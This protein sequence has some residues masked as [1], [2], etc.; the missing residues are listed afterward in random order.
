LEY[1][2]PG[3][4]ILTVLFASIYSTFSTIEDRREGFL[5]SVLVAPLPR[6]VI[7]V[8]KVTGG[9]VPAALQGTLLLLLVPAAGLHPSAAAWLGA[10]GWLLLLSVI[11][12]TLGFCFAWRTDSTQ[13]FHA[14]MN[15]LLMPLWLLSGAVFPAEGAAG[16]VQGLMRLNPLTYGVAGLRHFLHGQTLVLRAGLPPLGT[17]LGVLLLLGG[18]VSL[19]AVKEVQRR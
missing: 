15:L 4:V 2:F 8:G 17:C 1:F 13:G 19:W 9:A 16:W 3:I 11:L 7:V 10:A 6:G 14:V 12:T 18:G 5:P